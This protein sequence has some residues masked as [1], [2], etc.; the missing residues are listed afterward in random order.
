MLK[1]RLIAVI[2]VRDGRV[3]QSVKFKHTNVIHY[4][5]IHAIESFNKWAVDEIVLLNVSMDESSK[6]RFVSIIHKIS[7]ECFVPLSVGGWVTDIN[8][9]RTILKNGADKLVIN[10]HG[11]IHHEFITELAQN[12]GNQCVVVSIDSK[13]NEQ[14]EEFVI[15]D[16]GRKVT[17]IRTVDWSK[18]AESLGAGEIFIN[19]IDY[20]G[21][22]KGYN[23]KL[24]K[25]IALS[26]S[27]PVIA[28]GGVFTW[29]HLAEGIMAGGANAVAAANI[30]H[31]TEHSTKK[32]KKYLLDAGLNFRKI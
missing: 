8:Y 11:F 26:V 25:S 15:I 29:N 9:G 32:A 18:K 31:Y 23:I 3:V 1:N 16:R 6:D 10:T 19:S 20:D 22:R 30:F 5:P 4:D 7:E 24:I 28:M 21:N 2:L 17:E 12:F 13:Q 27:I 14:G